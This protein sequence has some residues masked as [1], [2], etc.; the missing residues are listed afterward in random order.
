M[1]EDKYKN[2]YRIPSARAQW[3]DYGR[4]AAYF[5]TICTANRE[6]YFG[7]IVDKKMQLSAIGVIADVFWH[8]IKKHAYFIELGE[9]IVMPNHIHGILIIDKPNEIIDIDATNENDNEHEY[10]YDN[11]ETRHA[12]S[13]QPPTQIPTQPQPQIQSQSPGQKR[14]QNQGKNTISSIIGGYKSVVTKHA[15]RLGYDFGWQSRFHDNII[16]DDKSYQ[17]IANYIVNNPMKWENDKFYS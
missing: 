3:W 17:F 10:E 15:R 11:V 9:F 14:F 16:K 13:L 7:N 2:K 5:I 12:L 4:N 8:E 6:H 1:S